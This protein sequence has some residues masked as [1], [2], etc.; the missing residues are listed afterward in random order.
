MLEKVQIILFNPINQSF[1]VLQTN[2]KRGSFWQNITGSCE[3]NEAPI[4]AAK[5]ELQEETGVIASQNTIRSLNAHQLFTDRNGNLIKEY[6]FLAV[7]DAE[8]TISLSSEHQ[9]F[10]WI[11]RKEIT[12]Y[13]YG[14]DSNQKAVIHSFSYIF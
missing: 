13:D 14:F 11:T 1:L 7:F 10:K 2:S 8:P 4:D 3:H 9:S 6:L 12:D 5:R